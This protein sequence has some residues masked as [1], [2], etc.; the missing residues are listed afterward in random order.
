[1]IGVFDSGVGGLTAVKQIF[2]Y[3]PGYQV[4]YFGDTA[5]VPYGSKSPETIRQYAL[6]DADFLVAR[7]AKIILIACNT[8]SSVA[9][10]LLNGHYP[11]PVL[12]II[13]PGVKAALSATKNGKIGVI[14]TMAT[15]NSGTHRNFLNRLDPSVR[16]HYQACPLLVSVAEHNTI[17]P[18][19]TRMIIEDYLKSLLRER[20]DTLILA[21]THFPHFRQIISE[22]VG[23]EV[24][25]IDPAEQAALD[26]SRLLEKNKKLAAS[27]TRGKR[28]KFFVSD[29]PH[30]FRQTCQQFLGEEIGHVNKVRIEDIF[31]LNGKNGK[32]K[33][34][35]GNRRA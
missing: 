32:S 5:R 19:I 18:E 25:L 6:E 13:M 14:G 3:L 11:V 15:V 17:R 28:H 10:D 26:L 1:M 24:A 2:K 23:E 33:K 7:G 27:L 4:V 34:L 31:V 8:V 16:V 29:L 12:D 9:Y 21:C 20:V 22:V 30:E 35:S